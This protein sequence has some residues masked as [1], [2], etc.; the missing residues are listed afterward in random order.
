MPNLSHVAQLLVSG[1]LPA[2]PMELS[3][4]PILTIGNC[5]QL[6]P[7]WWMC[8]AALSYVIR[9]KLKYAFPMAGQEALYSW[10]PVA[11]ASGH[12]K[13]TAK[14][15]DRRYYSLACIGA[16]I[17]LTVIIALLTGI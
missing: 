14:G 17:L 6:S 12:K 13:F 3:I 5:D 7:A 16:I 9:G 10:A 15:I 4:F 1:F 8:C 11:L 2:Y